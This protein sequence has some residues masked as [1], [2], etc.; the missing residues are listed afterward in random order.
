MT[1]S[2]SMELRV[3]V[4][5]DPALSSAA[6]E[7]IQEVLRRRWPVSW[8]YTPRPHPGVTHP[9]Q[10]RSV[11]PLAEG[12]A[13]ES[14]HRQLEE[15]LRAAVPTLTLHLR[16]RWSFP[17]SPNHQEIYESRWAPGTGSSRVP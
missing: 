16:T 2:Y 1:P 13:P 6:I 4:Y 8:D 9:V 5:S 10:W 7:A 11:V 3:E 17:E 12:T 15:D 14:L